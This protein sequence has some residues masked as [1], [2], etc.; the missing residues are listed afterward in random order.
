MGIRTLFAFS[1]ALIA[2]TAG[3]LRA[4]VNDSS[5]PNHIFAQFADGRFS[6]GSY[7]RSTIMVSSDGLNAT[8]C[9]AT[10][11]GLTVAGFGDGIR[12]FFTIA[13]G[14]WNIY[15]SPGSQIFRGG[16]LTLNFVAP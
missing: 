10:L 7:Y 11:H 8:D 2:L 5:A 9:T 16:Y 1:L 4:Q 12:R 13:S 14:G 15:K 3:E 6:D